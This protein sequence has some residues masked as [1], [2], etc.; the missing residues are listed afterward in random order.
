MS[1]GTDTI[2][3]KNKAMENEVHIGEKAFDERLQII[4]ASGEEAVDAGEGSEEEK[5]APLLVAVFDE[6]AAGRCAFAD[7]ESI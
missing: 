1:Q 3:A 2:M 6:K 7:A 5:C 4:N